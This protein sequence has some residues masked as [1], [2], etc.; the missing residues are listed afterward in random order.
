MCENVISN[1]KTNKTSIL[2]NAA[3]GTGKTIMGIKII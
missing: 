3:P 2:L 1:F